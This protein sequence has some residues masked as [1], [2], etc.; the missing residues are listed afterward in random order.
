MPGPR[1]RLLFAPV[2]ARVD[3]SAHN[4]RTGSESMS[5]RGH[6]GHDCV[7]AQDFRKPTV[8]R[9]RVRCLFWHLWDMLKDFEISAHRRGPEVISATA[10]EALLS[11]LG[12]CLRPGASRDQSELDLFRRRSGRMGPRCCD[13]HALYMIM[14]VCSPPACVCAR[15]ISAGRLARAMGSLVGQ[16]IPFWEAVRRGR[17]LQ[18]L[19]RSRNRA[20]AACRC[21]PSWRRCSRADQADEV[22]AR[23]AESSLYLSTALRGV[24]GRFH[25]VR[26]FAPL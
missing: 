18:G 3:G 11:Q 20:D 21:W 10:K 4:E 8:E 6:A 25:R 26:L 9:F 1:G 7:L 17:V 24:A 16:V 22:I 2:S 13:Q 23:S 14:A 15:I 12:H 5:V 19:E